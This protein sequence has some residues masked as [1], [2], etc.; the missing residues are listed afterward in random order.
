MLMVSCS[1]FLGPEDNTALSESTD[2]DEW[3][4]VISGLQFDENTD[5]RIQMLLE[6]LVG[7]S[8]CQDEQHISGNISRL[9]IAGNSLAPV[10]LNIEKQSTVEIGLK[11]VSD[12]SGYLPPASIYIRLF[13]GN[14]DKRPQISQQLR[15]N[16]WV[17]SC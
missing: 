12:F 17:I 7:E 16:A 3:I 11:S 1:F 9:V 15:P 13:R 14:S 8:G 6:Y 5:F 10:A 4:A 2:Q